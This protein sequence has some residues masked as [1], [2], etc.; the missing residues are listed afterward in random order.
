[1][2]PKSF[3][4][5]AIIIVVSVIILLF[6]SAFSAVLLYKHYHSRR[7]RNISLVGQNATSHTDGNQVDY[8]ELYVMSVLSTGTGE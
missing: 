7:K 3:L 2:T 4:L 1:M 5:V 8:T 6:L